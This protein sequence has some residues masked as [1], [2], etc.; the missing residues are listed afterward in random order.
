MDNQLK[1]EI[2]DPKN[3]EQI[4]D[5]KIRTS[6]ITKEFSLREVENDIAYLK[7]TQKE[8]EGQ[9]H[10]EEAK[11]QN[12]AH[13]HPKVL[14]LSEEDMQATYLYQKSVSFVKIGLDKLK[15]VMDQLAQYDQ[16]KQAIKEQTGLFIEPSAAA[17]TAPVEQSPEASTNEQSNA[18]Q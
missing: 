4:L 1:Y 10:L 8:L 12:I 11:K 7:K 6:G 17:Q 15:E 14:T 9:I 16:E 5:V 18:G 2:V 13:F 3:S